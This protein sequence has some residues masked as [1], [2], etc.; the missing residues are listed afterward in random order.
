MV[1]RHVLS[2]PCLG[3]VGHE[4]IYSYS[5]LLVS[6]VKREKLLQISILTRLPLLIWEQAAWPSPVASGQLTAPRTIIQPYLSGGAMIHGLL[7]HRPTTP[8]GSSN[9]SAVFP[10]YT[11]VTNGPAD[12]S[13]TRQRN[14]TATKRPLTICAELTKNSTPLRQ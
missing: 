2:I 14:S 13:T 6:R 12:R 11:V 1:K 8:N 3:C 9:T 7:G 5:V 10:Q 4:A